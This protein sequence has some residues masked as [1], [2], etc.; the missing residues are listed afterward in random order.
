MY[1]RYPPGPPSMSIPPVQAPLPTSGTHTYMRPAGRPGSSSFT[2]TIST[3]TAMDPMRAQ[4]AVPLRTLLYMG[5]I[6]ISPL[7]LPFLSL[8]PFAPLLRLR[9][10]R[11][12]VSRGPSW[13]LSSPQ[14]ATRSSTLPFSTRYTSHLRR[15]PPPILISLLHLPPSSRTSLFCAH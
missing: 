13:S 8:L 12:F 2:S 9:P 3:S 5:V 11:L 7:L 4:S 14:G 6:L 15:S 1:L 10:S